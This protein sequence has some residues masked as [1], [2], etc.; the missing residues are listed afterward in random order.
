[1]KK[2]QVISQL[3]KTK[4]G[5]QPSMP[6][7]ALQKAYPETTLP[8]IRKIIWNLLAEELAFIHP[9]PKIHLKKL[10]NKKSKIFLLTRPFS[11]KGFSVI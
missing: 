8:Y 6:L 11:E 5:K 2:K 9:S 4:W 3:C 7:I 10:T 1:L